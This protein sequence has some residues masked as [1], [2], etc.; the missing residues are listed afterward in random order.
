MKLLRHP[1][2][3]TFDRPLVL[4]I[5]NFDGLHVGHQALLRHLVTRAAQ[6]GAD[7]AVLSFD[8][9][10]LKVLAPEKA[11]K[12]I[13][14][15]RDRIELMGRHGIDWLLI[16]RFDL[17]FSRLGPREFVEKC[18]VTAL[19]PALLVVGSDFA[20]GRHRTGRVENL[21]SL[22]REFGFEVEVFAPVRLNGERVSCS[23]VRELVHSG[24]VRECLPL[25]GRRHFV[26]GRVAFGHQ[27]GKM[28]GFPT[29]NVLTK[30]EVIPPDGVYATLAEARGKTLQSVTN[31]GTN[32]TFGNLGR[33]IEA[34]IFDFSEDIYGER[35][36]VS[37]VER[38]REEIK[39]PSVQVLVE[40]IR[41]DAL[42][43]RE[44]LREL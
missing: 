21:S 10:P 31:I 33:T 29:A 44:V 35:I 3:A 23:R 39:F 11:P 14:S 7:S 9:H 26:T 4:S 16:Q 25:L 38:I 37:F 36:R 32:P 6:L 40:Q 43:A 13:L 22:G 15:R 5:G 17:A 8:P 20:F 41:K 24:K 30:T 2:R 1:V 28:I 34:H 12:L 42:R 18:L 19:R 27:R